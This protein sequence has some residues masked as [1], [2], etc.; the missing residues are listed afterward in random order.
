MYQYTGKDRTG[1]L[2][3]LLLHLK[4]ASEE[5]ILRDYSLSRYAYSDMD[6]TSATVASLTQSDLD[7]KVF[8]DAPVE[9]MRHAI[10]FLESRYGSV[11]NY[12]LQAQ[13][14]DQEWIEKLRSL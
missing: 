10:R 5:E 11:E 7:L 8:F 3:M 13:G 4:G 12:V 9:A 1:L 14:V 6:D 2:S